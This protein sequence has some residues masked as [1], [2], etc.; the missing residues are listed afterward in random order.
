[1]PYMLASHG[2]NTLG[3]ELQESS[4]AGHLCFRT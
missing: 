1:L 3:V 2:S 4:A